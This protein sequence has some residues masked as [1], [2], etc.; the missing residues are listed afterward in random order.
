MNKEDLVILVRPERVY[1]QGF[2]K[3]INLINQIKKQ[4]E[5]CHVATMSYGPEDFVFLRGNS[6]DYTESEIDCYQLINTYCKEISAVTCDVFNTDVF[7]ESTLPNFISNN[8]VN[9]IQFFL[10]P[11]YSYHFQVAWITNYLSDKGYRLN[12]RAL[13]IGFAKAV[14]GWTSFIPIEK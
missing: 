7:I 11:T 4:T 10:D 6:F 14:D 2:E 13:S 12:V 5:L 1:E 3:T 9:Q 8:R